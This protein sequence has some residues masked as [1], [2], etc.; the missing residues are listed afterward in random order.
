MK[1]IM[2]DPQGTPA[3]RAGW[4]WHGFF[5]VTTWPS[6]GRLEGDIGVEYSGGH[7]GLMPHP[8]AQSQISSLLTLDTR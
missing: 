4:Q 3:R 5:M 6:G 2:H 7:L 8:Q 1:Y